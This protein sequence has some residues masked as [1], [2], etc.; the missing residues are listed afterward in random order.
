MNVN[1]YLFLWLSV[2]FQV[3]HFF[4]DFIFQNVWMLQKSRAGW[5][6]VLPLSIHCAIHASAT[7]AVCLYLAPSYWWL[8]A[9]DFAIHFVM[10]R[11]KAGPK[12]LG[13]FH[14]VRGQGFWISFG[15]D[16]MVHH[17]T[18]IYIAW[19]LAGLPTSV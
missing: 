1:V 4:A 10:D 3:K 11:F 12:Y 13:R 2:F 7:L 19:I 6:F 15:F 14:D 16:Q 8:A 18:H 5:D 9:M 17:L